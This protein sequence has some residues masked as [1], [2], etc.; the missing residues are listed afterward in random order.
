M[1]NTSNANNRLK[2]NERPLPG[3]DVTVT[4]LSALKTFYSYVE[5][6]S[7]SQWHS[8]GKQNAGMVY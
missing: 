4:S 8:V 1:S 5:R 6:F 7:K 3:D 2:E